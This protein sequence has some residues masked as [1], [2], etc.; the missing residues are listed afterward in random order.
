MS[1]RDQNI[2]PDPEHNW[3]RINYP[4]LPSTMSAAE[5]A[6]KQGIRTKIGSLRRVA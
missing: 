1:S 6:E 5:R 3:Q 2:Q 4:P